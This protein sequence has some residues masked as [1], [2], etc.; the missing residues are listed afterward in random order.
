M[1]CNTI[2]LVSRLIWNRFRWKFIDIFEDVCSLYTCFSADSFHLV[3]CIMPCESSGRFFWAT[4]YY[5]YL[6]H[7]LY[8]HYHFYLLHFIA[9]YVLMLCHIPDLFCL[10]ESW[11]TRTITS[12]PLKCSVLFLE[13]ILCA[14]VAHTHTWN[15]ET[16]SYLITGLLYL[17]HKEVLHH[18][19]W[20][21]YF[22][23]N[24]LMDFM[25]RVDVKFWEWVPKQRD[26]LLLYRFLLTWAE[27]KLVMVPEQQKMF[28]S[29]LQM[30]SD[31]WANF[32]ARPQ[33]GVSALSFL[34]YLDAV[35]WVSRRA[36][37]KTVP[38]ILKGFV[39][40]QVEE[41]LR[42]ETH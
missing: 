15:T 16:A 20:Q 9:L 28:I 37:M 12:L 13:T 30:F 18:P 17:I 29:I 19:P 8:H 27:P 41:E 7:Y 2:S 22:E 5:T 40:E 14:F 25:K 26:S 38:L 39:L 42:G 32:E 6:N 4:R 24:R 36:S 21:C 23:E 3:C 1:T 10:T 35:D 34:Q 11:I 31:K 33:V